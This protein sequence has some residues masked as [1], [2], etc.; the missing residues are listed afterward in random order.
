MHPTLR[1]ILTNG[2]P[3][4]AFLAVIGFMMAEVTGIWLDSQTPAARPGLDPVLAEP[5]PEVRTAT[6]ADVTDGLRFRLPAVMA[7]WG[8]LLVSVFELVLWFWRGPRSTITPPPPKAPPKVM[9]DEVEQ[10]LN[11]LLQ[12]AEAAEAARGAKPAEPPTSA[13]PPTPPTTT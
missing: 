2:L 4:A 10:L 5:P 3:A 11:Q 7:L 6:G 12:Q 1:R 8:F 9:D 13:P